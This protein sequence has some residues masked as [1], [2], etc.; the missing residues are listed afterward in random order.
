MK[1]P[2]RAAVNS[3]QAILGMR[4]TVIGDALDELAGRFAADGA[5]VRAC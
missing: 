4:D 1:A 5:L 3:N 2:G